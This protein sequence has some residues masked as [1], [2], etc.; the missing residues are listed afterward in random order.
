MMMMTM[1]MKMARKLIL[2]Y[3]L[4]DPQIASLVDAW[5]I[6]HRLPSS[7]CDTRSTQLWCRRH[8]N[9][10][11]GSTIDDDEITT[12]SR[13]RR[14]MV[15]QLG[16]WM[17]VVGMA[18]VMTV[19]ATPALA[20]EVDPFAAMDELLSS[21]TSTGLPQAFTSQRGGGNTSPTTTTATTT[22]NNNNPDKTTAAPTID[23]KTNTISPI[24][25]SDMAAA[26]Q[27]SKQRR[28]IAPRTHG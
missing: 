21:D 1:T 20:A 23:S 5:A 15:L 25:T 26:L 19:L 11:S 24:Q 6:V 3:L 2:L 28:S 4:F 14:S 9:K 7:Q 18:K 22:A 8:D 16:S 13:S 12:I 17:P 10:S 27:E